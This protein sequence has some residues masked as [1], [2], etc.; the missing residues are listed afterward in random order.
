VKK[1]AAGGT[2]SEVVVVQG[3]G[4]CNTSPGYYRF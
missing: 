1:E 3:R 2:F 4:S